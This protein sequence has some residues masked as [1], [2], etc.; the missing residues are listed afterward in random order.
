[1]SSMKSSW[2][3]ARNY[4]SLVAEGSSSFVIAACLGVAGRALIK[5]PVAKVIWYVGSASIAVVASEHIGKAVEANV[6]E[7]QE[8]VIEM[9]IAIQEV[10]DS[11]KD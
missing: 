6:E 2:V 5:N 10:K 1:M 3:K 11:L 9:Q 7:I 8:S 4:I